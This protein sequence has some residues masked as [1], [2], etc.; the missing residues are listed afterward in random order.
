AVLLFLE[1][2]RLIGKP[3]LFFSI[4]LALFVAFLL[5]GSKHN[6][7]LYAASVASGQGSIP[8]LVPFA[9]YYLVSRPS[10]SSSDE[11]QLLALLLSR[12]DLFSFIHFPFSYV[13]YFG[14][15]ALFVILLAGTLV[16]RISPSPKL[17]S[18]VACVG[19]VLFGAFILR[20]H[21]SGH[22]D[23]DSTRLTIS[24]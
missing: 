22:L 4:F 2:A 21:Y 10:D 1:A 12:A 5:V 7:L 16:A 19:Y 14:Y 3:R 8:V 24:G 15:T 23:Y 13:I 20:P 11:S 18:I 17:I 6:L 9:V